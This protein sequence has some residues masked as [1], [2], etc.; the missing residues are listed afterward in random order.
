[1]RVL[2]NSEG[3]VLT[4]NGVFYSASGTGTIEEV[5]WHQCPELVRNYLDNVTYDPSDY[6][7]SQIAN[8]APSSPD[9]NNTKP[10]GYTFDGVTYYNEV[11]SIE[12]PFS[13]S[14]KAGTITPLDKLRWIN[15]TTPNVRDIG[16]GNCD[17]GTVKYIKELVECFNKAVDGFNQ[18]KDNF[19]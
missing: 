8:Y 2:I 12:T 13:S 3:K 15:T 17:G 9:A 14:N 1:M 10:V 6:S 18:L 16:G 11:P 5:K 7:I 4:N 19:E